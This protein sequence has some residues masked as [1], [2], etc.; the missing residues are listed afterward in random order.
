MSSNELLS[1][2]VYEWK[3]ATWASQK[4]KNPYGKLNS[5]IS[6]M[7]LNLH[8]AIESE[9]RHFFFDVEF[10]KINENALWFP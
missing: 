9:I 7:H 4:I 3:K 8:T 1:S 2:A 6:K 10:L 5:N